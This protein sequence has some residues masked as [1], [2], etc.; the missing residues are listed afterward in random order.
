[1]RPPT[2]AYRTYRTYRDVTRRL[3]HRANHGTY[4]TQLPKI[5]LLSRRGALQHVSWSWVR[6][7]A[8][9]LRRQDGRR[10]V[11]TNNPEE[12]GYEKT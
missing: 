10:S 11:A 4:S 7:R 1:M 9:T 6:S 12:R 3:T 5:S 2:W 8:L